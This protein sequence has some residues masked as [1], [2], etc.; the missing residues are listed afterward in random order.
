MSNLPG[1]KPRQE[2][3]D[4]VGLGVPEHLLEGTGLERRVA[5]ADAAAFA[6][7]RAA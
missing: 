2:L 5:E 1:T 7:A 4:A 3:G 6:H